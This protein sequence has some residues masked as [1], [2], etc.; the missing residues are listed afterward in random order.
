MAEGAA[1][2]RG[3]RLYR[4]VSFKR[5]ERWIGPEEGGGAVL[6]GEPPSLQQQQQCPAGHP[7][8]GQPPSATRAQ[9]QQPQEEEA[10][11]PIGR[12]RSPSRAA[13]FSVSRNVARLAA[14]ASA[15][16]GGRA[17]RS[18]SPSVRQLSQ[19]F[20]APR[21]GAGGGGGTE[22]P[23]AAAGEAA[24]AAALPA[25]R[26]RRSTCGGAHDEP[27]GG[28]GDPAAP[29]PPP[30]RARALS[31]TPRGGGEAAALDW[32]SVTEMRKLF[33]ESFRRQQQQQQQQAA[34][35]TTTG[36]RGEAQQRADDGAGFL[37]GRAAPPCPAAKARQPGLGPPGPASHAKLDSGAAPLLLPDGTG[38]A[39]AA[40][41]RPCC[42]P[43]DERRETPPP[44]PPRSCI[45]FRAHRL[46][47]RADAERAPPPQ[48]QRWDSLHSWHSSA[49]KA[50]AAA[51]GPSSSSP[52]AAIAALGPC[53]RGEISSSEEELLGPRAEVS[54]GTAAP[55]APPGA[56][57]A[58]GRP[59]SLERSS[60][61]EDESHLLMM[62][63]K[64]SL[65]KKR[66]EEPEHP[67]QALAPDGLAG[68][69]WYLRAQEDLC[70]FLSLP[71]DDRVTPALE[72]E[73]V[74][75]GS[76]F[77][78]AVAAGGTEGHRPFAQR[79]S[80][81]F[82]LGASGSLSSSPALPQV[83]RVS[84]VSIPPF[85][86][87]PC[88]SRSSSR[89]SSAETLK[90]EEN[91][92]GTWAGPGQNAARSPAAVFRSP[93]FSQS[94][95]LSRLQP[96]VRARPKLPLGMV[97][98]RQELPSAEN[99]H[100][101]GAQAVEKL[102]HR[103]SMS[104]P[105]IATETLALLSF[106]KSDLS[107]L[108]ARKKGSRAGD[109][110]EVTLGASNHHGAAAGHPLVGRTHSEA[111]L[112]DRWGL[113]SRPTLKDLTATL[114]RAKSFTC[115]D[116]P[117]PRRLFLQNTMKQSSSELF[118]STFGD[119]DGAVSDGEVVRSG[120]DGLPVV[121]QD[122]YIQEA[123]QVFEKISRIGSQHDYNFAGAQKDIKVGQNGQETWQL[124]TSE[125]SPGQHL[126][127]ADSEGNF[128]C[129]RSFEE[130][131]GPESTMTD[132]GIVTELETGS[133]Y[134][135]LSPSA[136][137][138]KSV[139]QRG[140]EAG[141]AAMKEMLLM[142]HTAKESNEKAGVAD[143][144][145]SNKMVPQGL[146]EAPS[147]PSALRRRRKFPSVGNTGSESSNGSNGE[148]NGEAYRSLSDPMPH[149]RR[150]I[151][152]D[153][154]NFSVD[155]NL[156]GSLNSKSG[157]PESSAVALSECTGS[158]ASD[159]SVC[160]DGLRDYST[161][162]Q[163]IVSQPG[164]MDKVM[165]EKGNGKTVKKKSFS[166]P[167]RRG[168]LAGAGFDGP[169][170]PISE[171]DQS[172]L[173]SSSEPILSE[174]GEERREED[175]AQPY[176]QPARILSTPPEDG[177]V[178]VAQD[179]GFH[180]KLAEVLSPRIVRRSSKKRT[181]RASSQETRNEDAGPSPDVPTALSRV[182]SASKHVRHTSE[183]AT[184]IPLSDANLPAPLAQ[185][186]C[187]GPA[188]LLQLPTKPGQVAQAPSLEDVSKPC[189]LA[190][191]SG[192]PPCARIVDTPKSSPATPTSTEPKLPRCPKHHEDPGSGIIRSRPQVDMRKHVIMTL[193]DTEQSYVESLRT[194]MLGYMK[195]LK[196]PENSILC[197]PSLVDEIFDQIPELLEHHEGF[198]EQITECMQNWHEKQKVGDILVQS[199]SKDILVN[200]YSAYI[201]NFLNAK[202][203]VRI[204]KEAK[205]AF[206]KFLEQNMRENKEKQAL[207]DLMI[208]PVQRIPRYELLVKDLLKHTP[209]EHPDHPYLIEA[210]RNI[211]QVAERINKGM[212][213][214]EE[215]ERNARI[216]QEIES[217]IEGME[218]LQAPL[219]KFLRQE[220]VV[221]MKA[222]GGKKDRSL[223]LF[224]DLL[225]CTTLK[226]K[227]GSLRRSSM[228]L[229]TAAS[230]IDTASKYKLLWKMPLEDVDIV[231]GTSQSTNRESI[232]KAITRLDED[233]STLGQVSKLSETLSFPHQSLD[234]VIKDLMAAIHRELA[235]KQSLSFSMSFP[236]NKMELTVTKP[237]GTESYLFEFPNPDA[238]QSFEQAFED[239]KKKLASSKNFLDPDFLKAIPIM[240][241]RSGMQFSC[242]SP[243]HH[244]PEN[245]YE[246]WVCN[247]DGY[248]GQVCL[249]SVRKEPLVE[250]CIA[251]C[252]ARILCIASVPGLK[253]VYRERPESLTS[254]SSEPA[255]TTTLEES[256]PQQCLHISISGSSLELSE[257]VDNANREL[258][259]FDS[260][261]T[262][263]ESSPSPSSTLQSQASH[264]TISSSFGNEEIPGSK[265]VTAETTSSEEE[266]DPAGFLSIAT[267][268]AQNSESPMDGQ[269][270]RRS[271]RGSFTRGSLEDLLSLDPEAYQG[272]MWLGTEDG[273]IHVYQSSDN[274]RN[275]KNSM[276]MQHSAS[277]TCILYLDNQVFV[278]LA[279]GELVVYQ[280]EPG[281]F[282]DSQNSKSLALGSP[283]SPI[284]KMV[285]VGGKL[286]CGCQNRIIILN[287]SLLQQEHTFHVGPDSNRSVTCMVH[288][289]VGVWVSL[290]GSA[291]V[292]LYHPASYD[293]LAEVDVTPPVHKM[294][295]GSDAII[296]Q[297]KAA[298]LRIT[299]L[300]ACK[301]LLWIGTSAGVVLT[302]SMM[303]Y[304][305]SLKTSPLPVGLSQGHTGHVRFLT[306]IELP[307]DFDVLFPLPRDPGAEKLNELEKRDSTRHRSSKSK[308]LVISGGDGYEDFRLANSSETVGRDDS[309]NHL[310][311]WR[312]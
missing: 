237:D 26:G 235:E 62:P 68:M 228:S 9:Q 230:V 255:H 259:P 308:M 55:F 243:S 310:L 305:S 70:Q 276:K 87:S 136:V 148:S 64:H 220:M 49:S 286:W 153:A 191:N 81:G 143:E 113:G 90:E 307:E 298:C 278:S 280:R 94:D 240:K 52:A 79:L 22:G 258:V 268:F 297:H 260:D 273:C 10:A 103:K 174:R 7:C 169:G 306:S 138:W 11:E 242:A 225:V 222:V 236:P 185:N 166:D 42:F 198:L 154:K 271:S 261:D 157:I 168:E 32:P 294:L 201:D 238:R 8:Q 179:Y 100:C 158:A 27:P 251:V 163:N 144:A 46:P 223:F 245:A 246:V 219:R 80:E 116:K 170:E 33:G 82:A 51:P 156:L 65:R 37:R 196:L 232:Q 210:Q 183:P 28:G 231:K 299:A 202:D 195:P 24:A 275:R 69:D 206:M 93:S 109:A 182:R 118:L 215:V 269:A 25:P 244:N 73:A 283:G 76:S 34:T 61:S 285:A 133:T 57:G 233:L 121:I 178:D 112:P 95:G 281:H 267:T 48:P 212:K 302:L 218:D 78:D 296:R 216:V 71:G 111:P 186:V 96:Q 289:S 127:E 67:G 249:L 92:A 29:P 45:P 252:S 38:M 4:S 282:W 160:S 239:T 165:D 12:R 126:Q 197:D 89:Y 300:L 207:S 14:T 253:R 107:E 264:S 270:M 266:Q 263:D 3:A 149:R 43:P 272:S 125:D 204:A 194:L 140:G 290:Q 124:S 193:L 187:S 262:D 97:R 190:L 309:T 77:S 199:F 188:D 122:Q 44:P 2:G 147:T 132:E 277:V 192:E 175:G 41:E 86:P 54:Q 130:L 13:S 208:K 295:A 304:A 234:D 141:P 17:L 200:I 224:T 20:C 102:K 142:N 164:A 184:F 171:M 180:P 301:D 128:S 21:G 105:D 256:G 6:R 60:G 312:V 254:P 248:V 119:H 155:S 227:S 162:I 217:H 5:L 117:A 279:N 99:L 205:P 288:S 66:K 40:G 229:Y 284:T 83:S 134:G 241:T 123:R 110:E 72:A 50:P 189:V 98:A 287:T 75:A 120:E 152:E 106:L 131:S 74:G 203:A 59:G 115:P 1:E 221:E 114:R 247:S 18:L 88:G 39:T 19:R 30:P 291:Q 58:S 265:D 213:S 145:L 16:A 226:R 146:L 167:S 159:L 274:I 150:S 56:A 211:K 15:P 293:Q 177:A 137:V 151:P 101:C 311:L 214:A 91:W 85:A 303:A 257:P 181:N 23:E 35:M 104:N 31:E 176:P 108:K 84:K 53:T 63:R 135:Y 139:N 250:A 172:I 36:S 161:V 47:P 292:R 129:G 173:P 209:E